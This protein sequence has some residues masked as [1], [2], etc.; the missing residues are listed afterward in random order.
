MFAITRGPS[1]KPACAATTSSSPSEISV[2]STS[3]VADG[4]AAEVPAAEDVLR[5][6]GVHRLA[7]RVVDVEQQVA[8]QD[9]AGGEGQRDRHVDHGPLAGGDARLAH[10]LEA[11]RHR[12]DAGVGAAA[13]G[14]GAQQQQRHAGEPQRREPRVEPLVELVGDLRD[15]CGDG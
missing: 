12:L 7:R 14:V 11:V 6:D 5:E 13:E 9:A 2:T 3:A 4:E 8:D 15:A 10:D 1:M